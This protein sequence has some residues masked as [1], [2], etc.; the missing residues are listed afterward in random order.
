MK[1]SPPCLEAMPG[2]SYYY[3]DRLWGWR[4]E[5]NKVSSLIW[6]T[7]ALAIDCVNDTYLVRAAA[8]DARQW[9]VAV[10]GGD[11]GDALYFAFDE[12][13]RDDNYL[14]GVASAAAAAALLSTM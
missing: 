13:H 8:V 5:R 3:S 7:P 12:W 1:G 10:G 4:G 11:I 6:H 2:V 9:M 14:D